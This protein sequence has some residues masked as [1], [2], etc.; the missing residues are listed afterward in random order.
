[1]VQTHVIRLQ[2][3]EGR[4]EHDQIAFCAFHSFLMKVQT[5]AGYIHATHAS[6]QPGD[7]DCGLLLSP[8]KWRQHRRESWD[9]A[10]ACAKIYPLKINNFKINLITEQTV[11]T[12][13]SDIK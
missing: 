8:A 1:M 10:T 9:Q 4:D 12:I 3:A 5:N 13:I 2:G 7:W 6:K 11:V